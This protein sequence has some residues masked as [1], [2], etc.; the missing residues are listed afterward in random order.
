ME[1]FNYVKWD[2]KFVIGIVPI[3]EQ[4]KKLVELCNALYEKVWTARKDDTDEWKVQTAVT[5]KECVNYVATHFSY[6]EKIMKAVNYTNY[7]AHKKR[8][9]EFTQKLL[10]VSSNFN[11]LTVKEALD[12]SKFL[13]DWIFEHISYEDRL[14]VKPVQEYMKNSKIQK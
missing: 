13:I 2:A 4:H 1:D 11:N 14:Y 5:L 7:P 3:D 9:D 12:F 6:E 8:H 10:D